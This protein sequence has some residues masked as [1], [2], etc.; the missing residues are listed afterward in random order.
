MPLQLPLVFCCK[1]LYR[2]RLHLLSLVLLLLVMSNYNT[3]KR[4]RGVE[5]ERGESQ[6]TIMVCFYFI[7]SIANYSR[8]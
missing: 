4:F 5:G 8:A 7:A 2:Y 6:V 3:D 1:L